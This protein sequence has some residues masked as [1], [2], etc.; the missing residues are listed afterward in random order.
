M[1]SGTTSLIAHIG[2]PTAAFKAPMI[3]NPWFERE[4]IDA[5]VVPMGV[6]AQ[7]FPQVLAALFKLTNIHGAL[8]TMPHK[9]SVV[10]LLDETT[11]TVKIAG[12]CNAVLR[13]PDGSLLGD[14]F[15]GTGFVRG[16]QRKGLK[17][18]GA[19]SLVVGCGGVGSAIA[20]SLAAAGIGAITLFDAQAAAAH[21]L[22][23]RLQQHYP[24]LVVHTGSN[25]PAGQDLVINATPLG[26]N[27][28]D[29]L[30][31]DMARL[32]PG[33]FVGE[34]VMKTEMTAFLKAAQ[35]R[36]CAVQ[37]GSDMLFEQIPAYLEFFG[38]PSTTPDVLRSVARLS[39]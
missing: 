15:D 7:D 29:P 10:G 8:I 37:V 4:G 31:L 28:G 9:V 13:R 32:A 39:Y 3:Y 25:D 6:Q 18:H 14:M 33:T 35:A 11:P 38:F 27:E 19:R 1:I 2:Y 21:A 17:L 36:G 5:V 34:V 26:M 30:P 20:A 23:G 22:G 12:S 16:V 24:Q